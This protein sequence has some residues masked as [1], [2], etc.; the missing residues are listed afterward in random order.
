MDSSGRIYSVKPAPKVFFTLANAILAEDTGGERFVTGILLRL[1]P[2]TRKMVY[3]NAGHPPG[4]VL[5]ADGKVKA[6]LKRTCIALGLFSGATFSPGAEVQLVP[7]DLVLLL[8]DGVP[9]TI[10]SNN[11]M[12][13]MERAVN[14]CGKTVIGRAGKSWGALPRPMEL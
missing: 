14:L 2:Q 1:D 10:S 3:A 8:T 13:G 9:D 4:Y 6:Q 7:A 12:F 5:A 11:A